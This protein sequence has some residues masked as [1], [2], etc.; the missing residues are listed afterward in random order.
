VVFCAL[1]VAALA[2]VQ[3]IDMELIDY[4]NN[5]GST[6][7]AGVN[8]FMIGKS[9]DDV[10]A[11]CGTILSKKHVPAH[12]TRFGSTGVTPDTSF[13]SRV[14]WPDCIH[15]IRNQL[16]C[17]S[18][19]AFSSSEVL[20]AR[21][22]IGSNDAINVIL[23]PQDLVS[24]DFGNQGCNGGNLDLVWDYLVNTGIVTDACYPYISGNGWSYPCNTTCQN[25]APW[26]PYLAKTG[27]K[28]GS[29]F[30]VK[31][32]PN[33]IAVEIQTNGP[34][35]AGFTVYQDFMSYTSGIYQHLTGSALGGHAV[36]MV[37]WGVQNNTDYWIVANSW[38]TDWGM[39]GYFWIL[40]GVNEC[41]IEADVWAGLAAV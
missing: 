25:G 12:K 5:A 26:Q 29:E 9:V 23:S 15:P 3:A 21:F 40:K 7:T 16:Q 19:W 24:C 18:C 37:G 34:V 10:K 28:V 31:A 17:G 8:K 22:C 36:K 39:D 27:Y 35:Q 30:D 1:V 6:W 33:T 38:G 20:S 41:G 32:R 4:I 11:L 14:Q 13:D 2:S